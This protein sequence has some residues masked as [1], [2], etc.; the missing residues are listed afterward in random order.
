MSRDPAQDPRLQ[1]LVA[2]L[3]R[4]RGALWG[5]RL[6]V[7][8]EHGVRTGAAF[9]MVAGGG[10]LLYALFAWSIALESTVPALL[11]A[12]AIVVGAGVL[13]VLVH[14]LPAM[15]RLPSRER[16]AAHL[17]VAT[18][19]HNRLSLMLEYLGKDELTAFE[20]AA[21]DE[22]FRWIKEMPAADALDAPGPGF[23][24]LEGARVVVGVLAVVLA[25]LVAPRA[26]DVAGDA[27]VVAIDGAGE[28]PTLED[29][30]RTRR[31]RI[32]DAVT[33]SVE[34]SLQDP[35]SERAVARR[36]A[37]ARAATA[38]SDQDQ[39]GERSPASGQP[40]S[41]RPMESRRARQSAASQG[42][43][44]QGDSAPP[45]PEEERAGER[46]KKPKETKTKVV[47]QRKKSDE[48]TGA[49]VGQSGAGGGSMSPVQSPWNQKDKSRDAPLPDVA[50]DQDLEDEIEEQEARGG[51]QPSLKD[52]R[53]ATSRDLSISGVG[54]EPGDGRGGPSQQKKA[55]GTAAL[56][57]GVP[58]PDFVRG[59]LN[60][61]T[62]KVTHERVEP[63]PG[64][65]EAQ[66][67]LAPKARVGREL[68]VQ[69][70]TVPT[71]L[72]PLIKKFLTTL[73]NPEG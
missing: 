68:E 46:K 17:D 50:A 26:L 23:R 36:A 55:R 41:G 62:T 49:T 48:K 27:A 56:I 65:G 9:A 73:R 59:Q 70:G 6:S 67:V 32:A 15:V 57:L 5:H 8:I 29:G 24:P 61:G 54:D 38:M 1:S 2:V 20:Q 39:D 25:F 43:P 22:G 47:P 10:V 64:E 16:A 11:E 13:G 72:T 44:T 19:G 60:P 37:E 33:A 14:V 31:D 42:D 45:P 4:A 3:E 7:A 12:V 53:G 63:V 66:A 28:T 51:T 52:R 58:L 71:H 18:K 35:E 21:L 69:K 40:G 30:D 34:R